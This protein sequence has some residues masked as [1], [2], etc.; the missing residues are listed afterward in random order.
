MLGRLPSSMP[1]N[2]MMI[3]GEA[4]RHQCNSYFLNAASSAQ[5]HTCLMLDFQLHVSLHLAKEVE[6][7]SVCIRSRLVEAV[8]THTEPRHVEEEYTSY[9]FR[10]SRH[11]PETRTYPCKHTLA[12]HTPKYYWHRTRMHRFAAAGKN[13]DRVPCSRFNLDLD[14]DI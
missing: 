14:P 11:S 3:R 5:T 1:R 2:W 7:V 12:P 13:V 9:N 6:V 10:C 4:A 8:Y